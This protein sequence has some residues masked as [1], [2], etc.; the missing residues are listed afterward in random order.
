M[1][2][3]SLNVP[4]RENQRRRMRAENFL[5][6]C[7]VEL[8]VAQQSSA[9]NKLSSHDTQSQTNNNRSGRPQRLPPGYQY[10]YKPRALAHKIYHSYIIFCCPLSNFH[11]NTTG[12]RRSLSLSP[13]LSLSLALSLSFEPPSL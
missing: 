8:L 11:A 3:H 1:R 12:T 10:V 5:E 6:A 9:P 7:F 4:L 13:P 2:W